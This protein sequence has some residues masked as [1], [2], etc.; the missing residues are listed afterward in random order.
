M[1]VAEIGIVGAGPAG[2]RAGELLAGQGAEVVVWDPRAPWEK[3][4][5]GGLTVGALRAFPE[6]NAL[7]D[8]WQEVRQVR[9][10]QDANTGFSFALAA[11]IRIVSR[12]DLARWQLERLEGAGA[13]VVPERVRSVERCPGGWRVTTA[14]GTQVVVRRLVGADGAAS[15]VRRVAAPELRVTL[16]PTR[17]AYPPGPDWPP[18]LVVRFEAQ[19]RGYAWDFPRL[20]HRSVGVLV[21]EVARGRQ[22][23]DEAV[24]RCRLDGAGGET[25]EL[26]R[27]GAVVGSAAAGHGDYRAVGGADLALLGDAAGFADPATG[28]GIG[29]AFR[30]AALLAEAYAADG[31]FASYPARARSR[32]EAEFRRMR[33]L[34]RLLYDL[35]GHAWLV[36]QAERSTS[37]LAFAIAVLNALN[38]HDTATV[39][40]LRR[41]WG[42]WRQTRPGDGVRHGPRRATVRPS[43]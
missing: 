42:T 13:R 22:T 40:F 17:V 3:P 11:P 10:E 19:T 35:R 21:D 27:A 1:L 14:V 8:A 26:R 39:A 4:C 16:D 23:L 43:G 31:S 29:N 12:K 25:A 9:V 37:V 20:D 28:E 5:G 38:E 33:W 36:P 7:A 15:L 30:S 32:F 34:R 18:T 24:D 2:A 41:W 6:L